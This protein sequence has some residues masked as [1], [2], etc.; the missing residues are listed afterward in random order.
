MIGQLHISIKPA[1][2]ANKT[3]GCPHK[4][5][6]EVDVAVPIISQAQ[7]NN[8]PHRYKRL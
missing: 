7:N 6:K 1:A 8:I 4:R 3:G 5:G 2:T